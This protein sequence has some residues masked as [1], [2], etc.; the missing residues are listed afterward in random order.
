MEKKIWKYAGFQ[1]L[2]FQMEDIKIEDLKKDK[3][4]VK[5]TKKME[6]EMIELKKKQE[7]QRLGI[8]KNQ[9]GFLNFEGIYLLKKSLLHVTFSK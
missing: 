3:S 9:V 4:Y 1:P 8:Q 6:K 2:V 7:K 5:L